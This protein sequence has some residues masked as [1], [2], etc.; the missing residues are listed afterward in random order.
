MQSLAEVTGLPG[1]SAER[2]LEIVDSV[3]GAWSDARVEDF[4]RH[5]SFTANDG[6][7]V[8]FSFAVSKASAAARV[9]FEPLD[10]S[11]RPFS[12][13]REGW[14]AAQRIRQV[15]GIDVGRF[16]RIKDLFSGAADGASFAMLYSAELDARAEVPLFKVYLNPSGQGS[17]PAKVVGAAM[18]R[19]GMADRWAALYRHLDR[20]TRGQ[21]G[22]EIALF[23]LDLGDSPDARVK[24]Y[25]RHAGCAAAEIDQ[26]ISFAGDHRPGWFT[27][28][29][30]CLYGDGVARLAKSPMTC[31]AFT[32]NTIRTCSATLYCPLDPNLASD[33][34]ADTRIG[35]VLDTVRIDPGIY[36]VARHTIC[37]SE[38]AGSNR[39]SWVSF[40]RPDDPVMTVYAGLDGSPRVLGT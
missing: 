21:A 39:L 28:I 26:A 23:A 27:E 19:L 33:A 37:G 12:S 9:L 2:Q 18:A 3:L 16:W 15:A 30:Y 6:S 31:L 38:L 8:E 29:L 10:G 4:D 17:D 14:A 22:P 36:R 20:S 35:A 11:A 40:K 34:V 7:P 5:H 24:I 13:A 1:G 25:L 32:E